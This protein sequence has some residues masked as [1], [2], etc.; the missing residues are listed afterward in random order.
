MCKYLL[1]HNYMYVYVNIIDPLKESQVL[2]AK[3]TFVDIVPVKH[4]L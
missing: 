4:T 1:T 2:S 3:M